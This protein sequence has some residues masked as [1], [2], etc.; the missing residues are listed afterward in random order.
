MDWSC[1]DHCVF[2]GRLVDFAPP[3]KHASLKH[4]VCPKTT[5]PGNNNGEH[6]RF[7]IALPL[8]LRRTTWYC[9]PGM[10]VEFVSL[11]ISVVHLGTPDRRPTTAFS[12]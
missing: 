5:S 9:R 1:F 6:I 3:K 4:T 7:V 10:H 8:Q 2:A 12:G 11:T